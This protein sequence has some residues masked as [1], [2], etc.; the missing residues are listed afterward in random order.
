M[1]SAVKTSLGVVLLIVIAGGMYWYTNMREAPTE[2]VTVEESGDSSLS[3]ATTLPTGSATE[4]DALDQDLSAI[5][6]QMNGFAE[7]N[8]S[9]TKGLADEPVQQAS[10]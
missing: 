7:D 9:V 6:A 5:E 3:A 4:D 10:L 2:G 1:T 8:A